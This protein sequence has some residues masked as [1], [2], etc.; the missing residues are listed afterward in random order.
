MKK[1]IALCLA[2]IFLTVSL[3]SILPS[4]ALFVRLDYVLQSLN[5]SIKGG[6]NDDAL[7]KV[8]ANVNFYTFDGEKHVLAN[9]IKVASLADTITIPDE[10]K[11]GN[12]FYNQGY[13]FV[14]W[15]VTGLYE[16]NGNN[17]ARAYKPGEQ[18]L[19]ALLEAEQGLIYT[20]YNIQFFETTGNFHPNIDLYD[21]YATDNTITV[22]QHSNDP[23]G[24]GLSY[25]AFSFFVWN[26]FEDLEEE[27]T[28]KA[29][30]DEVKYRY[31]YQDG[32]KSI[33]EPN[34]TDMANYDKALHELISKV[35]ITTNIVKYHVTASQNK[36]E[37]Y[38]HPKLLFSS[39]FRKVDGTSFFAVTDYYLNGD[40]NSKKNS[41]SFLYTTDG[42]EV[43]DGNGK[44]TDE[45][46]FISALTPYNEDL[47]LYVADNTPIENVTSRRDS[48]STSNINVDAACFATGTLITLA[49]GSKIP[50][51]QLTNKHYLRVYDHDFGRY[52]SAPVLLVMNSGN[53]LY[54]IAELTFAD[55][56]KL[57]LINERGLF[58]ITLNKYVYVTPDNCEEFVGHKFAK[59]RADGNGFDEVELLTANK[60][61]E[62]TG[63]YSVTTTYYINHFIN[64]Y[65]TLPGGYHW[66][67][68]YFE[69]GEN[70]KYDEQAKVRDIAIYG[71]FT[72]ED[73]APYLPEDMLFLFDVIY[74]AQYLKVAIGKGLASMEEILTVVQEWVVYYDLNGKLE[75]NQPQ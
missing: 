62:F 59:E 51:E 57:K 68:N 46:M 23:V 70:L 18:V 13:D 75:Q 50:V 71:L 47:I 44:L 30:T 20:L 29:N 35:G 58:D 26:R 9:S 5:L 40:T 21:I 39:S 74:P 34:G 37:F 22:Q 38:C 66:F 65:L 16:T 41:Y 54:D 8:S 2:L 6:D 28:G 25:S 45:N 15:S 11:V 33:L 3:S 63:C 1:I 56:E 60:R 53:E 42:H 67:G 55:G 52:T 49:D 17:L 24:D 7:E 43:Y 61:V 48:G 64:G 72:K 10:A 32:T 73:F 14:G 69:Y 19:L 4:S 12:V 27:R 31:H 36:I